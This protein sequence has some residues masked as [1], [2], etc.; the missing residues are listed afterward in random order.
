MPN[1]NAFTLE[2]IN[3]ILE[4]LNAHPGA[5]L[6]YIGSRYVPVL[7]RKGEDSIEWDNTGTYEPLTIVLYQGNSYTSRQ[8]VPVGI[9]IINQEYWANTGN[10]NAQIEQYRQDVADVKDQI[11]AANANIGNI[12]TQ[13]GEMKTQIGEIE[14]EVTDANEQISAANASI[15]TINTQ[16]GEINAQIDEIETEVRDGIYLCLGDSWVAGGTIANAIA[17]Q[18]NLTLINKAV[19]GASFTKYSTYVKTIAEE[20]NEAVSSIS[21]VS[22]VK[23]VTLVAGVNDVSHHDEINQSAINSAAAQALQS[24]RNNF[25]NAEIIF[26]ADAPYSTDFLSL[27]HYYYAVDQLQRVS[28]HQQV[29]FVNLYG[30]FNNSYYYQEDNLHPNNGGCGL[31]ASMLLGGSNKQVCSLTQASSDDYIYLYFT[32]EIVYLN[33]AFAAGSQRSITLDRYFAFRIML[34]VNKVG[35][36]V[37]LSSTEDAYSNY[38]DTITIPQSESKLYGFIIGTISPM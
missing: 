27:S 38:V 33:Y 30:M 20:I 14:T 22:L 23:L 7:G 16:I 35:D 3:Q 34:N 12:N 19:S 2:E 24:I 8:F 1:S 5:R 10:Y 25:P 13:I 17:K 31:V 32:N 29:C 21:D 28:Y 37:T 6:Q 36:P 26:A 9:E 11:S 15:G 4:Q 18:K